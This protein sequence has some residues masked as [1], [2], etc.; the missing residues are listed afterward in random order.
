MS[1]LLTADLY[2]PEIGDP[3]AIPISTRPYELD[4]RSSS[5]IA[6]GQKCIR[7]CQLNHT[8]CRA[9]VGDDGSEDSINPASVPSRLLR[10]YQNE[11]STL[12]AQTVGRD[13]E[14]Q[15]PTSEVSRKGFAILSYCWG[16]AQPIQLTR[17]T[18]ALGQNYPITILPKTLADAAWFTHQLGLEYLWVDALCIVQDDADDKGREIPRM[19]R[20]YGDATVAICAASA[21]TCSSGFLP[22]LPPTEDSTNY[23]FGPVALRVKTTTGE[24]GTIQALKEADYFGSHREREPI[25]KRGWTLQESL[26]SRRMLIFS[27]HHLYFSCRV[28][29]ASCG[30]REPLLKSRVIGMYQS[31]VPG[32]HTIWGLQRLFPIVSTWDKVVHEYTQR[33]LGFPEDKLLAIS[34]MAASLVRVAKEERALEFRYCA[35]MM[36]DLEG[37]D[38]GWKGELLW[39]VTQPATPLGTGALTS[40][41]SWSW[42]SLQAPIHRWQA[43]VDDFPEEDGIRLLDLN[44]PLADERNPFGAV[45]GGVI[46]LMARTRSLS[47]INRSESNMVVTMETTSK[48]KTYDDSS[49]SALIIRPDTMEVDSMMMADGGERILLVELIATRSNN[50]LRPNYPAGLLIT[51]RG[52]NSEKED[53]YQRVGI[54]EFTFQH[55]LKSKAHQ[56]L[57]FKQAAA[58]FENCELRELR[59]V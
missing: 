27:S 1:C 44:A 40:P 33:R 43:R 12:H 9:T 13:M 14:C 30:G 53:R 55:H 37:K 56:E 22:T 48:K 31:R 5:S 2:R 6:W 39:T 46:R 24:M 20:Y 41:P 21:G 16:E 35:G 23:V 15:I 58:L 3:A 7:Y 10:L 18:L 50:N 11:D 34:A 51:H 38:W 47:T 28:A 17:A 8:E 52:N 45:N 59:I 49:R 36:F 54:F 19:R 25:V 4:Y 42:A 29:N 32:I 57:V 26:L